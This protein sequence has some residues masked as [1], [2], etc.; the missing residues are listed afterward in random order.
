MDCIVD[1]NWNLEQLNDVVALPSICHWNYYDRGNIWQ[2]ALTTLSSLGQ[3][4]IPIF[5]FESAS[6]VTKLKILKAYFIK[7]IHGLSL[8]YIACN[9]FLLLFSFWD[10]SFASSL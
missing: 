6:R 5:L 1:R 9:A 10:G 2:L 4:F 3:L 7:S 8:S